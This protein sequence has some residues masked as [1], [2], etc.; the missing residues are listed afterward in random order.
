MLA[1]ACVERHPDF[2]TEL[3]GKTMTGLVPKQRDP[4]L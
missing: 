4:S 2:L 1:F 3:L